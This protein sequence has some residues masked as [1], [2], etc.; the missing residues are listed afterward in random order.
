MLQLF[1]CLVFVMGN[2]AERLKFLRSILG[3]NRKK[4]SKQYNIAYSTL[5]YWEN[6]SFLLGNSLSRGGAK[7]IIDSVTKNGVICSFNWLYFGQGQAPICN[8]YSIDYKF[9]LI[10]CR[11]YFSNNY[12]Q[13]EVKDS[14]ME[15]DYIFGSTIFLTEVALSELEN[16]K[17][18]L[19][20]DL[21][22]EL[23]FCFIS[24]FRDD[25]Y[26]LY[27]NKPKENNC[28]VISKA[29]KPLISC[30]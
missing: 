26:L 5:S 15:P 16:D 13:W 10:D 29:Y 2:R 25:R 30:Y 14:F 27:D 7:L 9:K 22:G 12:M 8:R 28:S 6:S 19:V 1:V 24:K 17:A 18:Y 20:A 23:R 4:F 11:E 3:L 21:V